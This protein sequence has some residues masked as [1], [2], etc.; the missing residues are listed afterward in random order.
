M[1]TTRFPTEKL[2]TLTGHNGPVNC[3][4][5]SSGTG[6]YI[7]TGSSDR[8][9]HLYNPHP[10]TTNPNAS[11]LIQ[12]YT[13]HGY[14]VL[15]L[16]VTPD[17]AKFASVGGDRLVFLWDVASGRTL[18][19][20]EGHFGRIP[21]SITSGSFDTTLRL[22]D[23]KSSSHKPIQVLSEAK[24]SISS[25]SI[26]DHEIV[27]GSVDGRIRTYDL[28]MGRVTTD[29]VGAPVTSVALTKYG[30]GA[31]LVSTLDATVRLFD[32]GNGTL[33]QSFKG[34]VNGDFRIGSCLGMRD[35]FVVSG[36]E[37]GV[38]YVWDILE[39][40]VRHRLKAHEGKV[41]SAVA[42][43][44]ARKEWCSAGTNGTVCVWGFRD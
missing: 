24:D 16:A 34:H 44:D 36:S 14:E 29:V 38:I 2:I 37:D 27:S 21:V 13:A 33:L 28:R 9:I 32:R 7:L 8:H 15:S 12:E 11:Q 5:Y 22:W 25:L 40:K 43:N 23:C 18:R 42:F 1:S 6:Q 4:T 3:V 30:S 35:A 39:G 26:Q 31:L 17:N 10:T 41:C 19:R 20:W